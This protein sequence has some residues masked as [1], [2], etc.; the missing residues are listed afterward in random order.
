M[1]LVTGKDTVFLPTFLKKN[2]GKLPV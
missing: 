1:I 2:D